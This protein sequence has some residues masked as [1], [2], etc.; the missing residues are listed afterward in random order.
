MRD[1]DKTKK[2]LGLLLYLELLLEAFPLPLHKDPCKDED[3]DESEQIVGARSLP[4]VLLALG[5]TNALH[6]YEN[7]D[8]ADVVG[9]Q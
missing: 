9:K 8:N 2:E 4:V 5:I 3:H 7:E 6:S 1:T